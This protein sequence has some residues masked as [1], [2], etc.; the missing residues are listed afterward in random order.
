MSTNKLKNALLIGLA[1]EVGSGVRNLF[2]YGQRYTGKAPEL[3]DDNYSFDAN[4]DR[5]YRT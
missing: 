2:Y 5:A 3:I 4:R 1:Y